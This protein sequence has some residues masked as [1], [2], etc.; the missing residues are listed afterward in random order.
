M[1]ID[2]VHKPAKKELKKVQ[3]IDFFT[4]LLQS[5]NELL[6]SEMPKKWLSPKF[7]SET[8]RVENYPDFKSD[9][10]SPTGL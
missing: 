5:D 4:I 6:V 10:A 1:N 2:S 8:K 9:S 3:S 7:V